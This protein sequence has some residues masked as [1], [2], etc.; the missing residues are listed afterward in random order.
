MPSGLS[1]PDPE[2]SAGFTVAPEV[3]YSP[4]VLL[5]L[6]VTKR[7]APETATPYGPFNPVTRDGFTAAP[8]V[9]YSPIA[10]PV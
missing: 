6:F 7:S 9:V 1:N 4:I 3:V 10:L 5:V 2:I 8:E